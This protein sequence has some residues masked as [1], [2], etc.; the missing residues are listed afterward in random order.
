MRDLV[1]RPGIKSRPPALRAQSLNH[2][3]MR[4]VPKVCIPNIEN[5]FLT[6][7]S[8]LCS[9]STQ[10]CVTLNE[11]PRP[12]TCKSAIS[13]PP[14]LLPILDQQWKVWVPAVLEVNLFSPCPCSHWSLFGVAISHGSSSVGFGLPPNNLSN[15]KANLTR[16]CYQWLPV[17]TL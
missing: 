7:Q 16:H 13:P 11:S 9:R 8:R 15:P 14:S 2:W 17:P 4:E 5:S 10:R 12:D 1:P 3:A 6:L